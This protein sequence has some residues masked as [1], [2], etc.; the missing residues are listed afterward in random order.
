MFKVGKFMLCAIIISASSFLLVGNNS[1][2]E[3]LPSEI[4]ISCPITFEYY[5][6]NLNSVDKLFKFSINRMELNKNV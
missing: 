2:S 5:L 1:K 3:I 6:E 4:E